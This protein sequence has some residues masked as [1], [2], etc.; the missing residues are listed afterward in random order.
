MRFFKC[1]AII[2][3]CVVSTFR[4]PDTLVATDDGEFKIVPGEVFVVYGPIRCKRRRW[5][6]G[7]HSE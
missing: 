3:Q 4:L 7:E 1:Q 2:G 5:H 6:R